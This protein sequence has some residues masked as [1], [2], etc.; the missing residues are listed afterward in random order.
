MYIAYFINQI[1]ECNL[2]IIR[3][4]IIIVKSLLNCNLKVCAVRLHIK[5]PPASSLICNKWKLLADNE[6]SPPSRQIYDATGDLR[7]LLESP[8]CFFLR[9]ESCIDA[10]NKDP[11][12]PPPLPLSASLCD[13]Q[14]VYVVNEAHH[15]VMELK[16]IYCVPCHNLLLNKLTV[17][18]KPPVMTC[19]AARGQCWHAEETGGAPGR[20][21]VPQVDTEGAEHHPS[22]KFLL[23]A[24]AA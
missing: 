5:S 3:C 22:C 21:Q 20:E 14:G 6:E 2:D 1:S 15:S 4:I 8:H 10:L 19:A 9:E 23:L 24:A 18:E 17:L 12:P 11:S 7:G 16:Y 13:K